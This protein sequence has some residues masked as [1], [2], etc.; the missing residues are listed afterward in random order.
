[1]HAQELFYLGNHSVGNAN[2]Y[3]MSTSLLVTGILI[4]GRAKR[5]RQSPETR[6]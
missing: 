4:G 5:Q 6:S 2:Y 3:P 1:M